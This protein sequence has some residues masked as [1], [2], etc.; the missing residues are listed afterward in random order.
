MNSIVIGNLILM[1]SFQDYDRESIG[2]ERIQPAKMAIG[3]VLMEDKKPWNKLL[4]I[5]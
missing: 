4:E 5:N 2:T 1:H 3:I